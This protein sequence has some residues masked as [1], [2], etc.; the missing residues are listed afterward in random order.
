MVEPLVA[1]VRINQ[2]RRQRFCWRQSRTTK[3]CRWF[4]MRLSATRAPTKCTSC[5]PTQ[6]KPSI[7][8]WLFFAV[9]ILEQWPGWFLRQSY[10]E[11]QIWSY[12][13]KQ[14]TF[15]KIKTGFLCK[16]GCGYVFGWFVHR[17]TV[18]S[19]DAE[20]ASQRRL[21]L[22]LRRDERRR[23]QFVVPGHK[24]PSMLWLS[25]VWPRRDVPTRFTWQAFNIQ[26]SERS[27]M[28]GCCCMCTVV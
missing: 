26:A 7:L 23:V 4:W 6:S 10:L 1:A 19:S 25:L 5:R 18:R 24:H 20:K 16:I 28:T 12:R 14:M 15:V 3:T 22:C 21:L 11:L 13:K 2:R 27:T 9:P 8:V 17:S